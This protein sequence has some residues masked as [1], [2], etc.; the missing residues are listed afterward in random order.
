MTINFNQSPL[1]KPRNPLRSKAQPGQD[2][3]SRPLPL[4]HHPKWSAFLQLFKQTLG[5]TP[6][7]HRP[8]FLELL[9][10]ADRL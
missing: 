8:H 9:D 5:L 1:I 10:Q 7:E 2:P 6:P 3:P 4:N